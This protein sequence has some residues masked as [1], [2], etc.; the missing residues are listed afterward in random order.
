MFDFCMTRCHPRRNTTV[1]GA[2]NSDNCM[3]IIANL[4]SRRLTVPFNPSMTNFWCFM[5]QSETATRWCL[6]WHLILDRQIGQVSECTCHLAMHMSWNWWPHWSEH[7]NLEGMIGSMQMTQCSLLRGRLLLS[8][9]H[10]ELSRS[11]FI[12]LHEERNER[13]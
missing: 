1:P 10:G 12:S 6:C 13:T 3:P 11:R 9:G 8:G 2:S 5:I 4:S 7:T